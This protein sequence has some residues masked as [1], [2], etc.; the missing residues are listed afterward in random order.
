MSFF[1]KNPDTSNMVKIA[2]DVTREIN[3]DQHIESVLHKDE[4]KLKLI[5]KEDI[6][7]L[8][9]DIGILKKL[10]RTG[11]FDMLVNHIDTSLDAI[12]ERE[13]KLVAA[14]NFLRNLSGKLMKHFLEEE[15]SLSKNPNFSKISS[16]LHLIDAD[17]H[18]LKSYENKLR[19]DINLF[20]SDIEEARKHL[21]NFKSSHS[22]LSL[23]ELLKALVRF[24]Q[25]FEYA[26]AVLNKFEN[27]EKQKEAFVIQLRTKLKNLAA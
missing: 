1:R 18:S 13:H 23:R 26:L 21:L 7:D 3:K 15:R 14:L 24:Q 4:A 27:I 12:E 9:E 17:E 19:E 5:L 11:Q 16:V 22:E 6:A 10:A 8:I 20:K 25:L 2:V